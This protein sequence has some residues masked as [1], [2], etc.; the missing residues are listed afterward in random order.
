MWPSQRDFIAKNLK[1][2]L[3]SPHHHSHFQQRS[4]SI[5]GHRE[6]RVY[7]EIPRPRTAQHYTHPKP[8]RAE[9]MPSS[10][11]ALLNRDTLILLKGAQPPSK[12]G[13]R[14]GYTLRT[15]EPE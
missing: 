7:R 12:N 10:N 6:Y 11:V 3:S 2:V 13:P 4:I 8:A 14:V 15:A 9:T 1:A 5:R